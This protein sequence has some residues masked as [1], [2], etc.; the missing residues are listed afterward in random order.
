MRDCGL[1][2]RPLHLLAKNRILPIHE[3]LPVQEE[4]PLQLVQIALA[5][6]I[7]PSGLFG[8]KKIKD[9]SY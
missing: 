7:L 4:K 2:I 9:I 6:I 8:M 5:M 1:I 3:I